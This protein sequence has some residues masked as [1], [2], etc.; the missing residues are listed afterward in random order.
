MKST[1]RKI[2]VILVIICMLFLH[3]YSFAAT[4]TVTGS[5]VRIRKE[6]S[7]TSEVIS[8]ATKGE[9]VEV[10]AE[11]DGWYKIN[12]E[13]ITGYISADFVETDS[14]VDNSS[15]TSEDNNTTPDNSLPTDDV[16]G[17]EAPIT[18]N[19][20]EGS[21]INSQITVTQDISVRNLPT[22]SS[23]NSGNVGNGAVVTVINELNNW[24]KINDGTTIGWALKTQVQG[25]ATVVPDDVSPVEPDDTNTVEPSDDT[26]IDNETEVPDTQK[27]DSTDTSDTSV[28]GKKGKINVDSAR[29]RESVDGAIISV[30]DLNDE[31]EILAEEGEWY[32]INVEEY[33]GCYIAKRL[34]TLD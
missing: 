32:K 11:E 16:N 1:I 10:L 9:K 7:A 27:P 15:L 5:S 24:V 28:V 34:V 26:P 13:D 8:V 22:F 29:I 33:K 25:T 3:N 4:G 19:D 14:Q 31:V 30:V 18:T 21:L 12:F 20:D 6:A 23:R 17:E 2:L